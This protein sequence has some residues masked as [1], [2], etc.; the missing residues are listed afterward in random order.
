[1]EVPG[2]YVRFLTSH[3]LVGISVISMSTPAT[4]PPPQPVTVMLES[5]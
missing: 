3:L 5:F 4:S 2:A 1:M